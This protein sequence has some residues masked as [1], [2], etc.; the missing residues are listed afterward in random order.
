MM[1]LAV[2]C[3][4]TVAPA[5]PAM[6]ESE[7][8]TLQFSIWSDE[9]NYIRKV[10]DQY[11]AEDRGIQVELQVIPEADYDD[12]LKVMLSGGA[13]VDLVDIRG[14]AQATTYASQGAILDIT[15]YINASSLD[16]SQYG[17]MWETSSYQGDYYTL[18]TRS[19]CWVLYYN[20]DLF[21][22]AGIEYPGQLTWDEYADLAVELQDKLGVYGGYWVPWIFQFASIQSGKYVDDD[23]TSALQ[24][25]LELLNRLYNEDNSHMSYAELTA[26]SAD[27]IAEFENG[28]CAMLPN[29]E[30]CVNMFLEDEASGECDIN[31]QV[32][33]M[34]VPDGV[35]DNTTWG[36]FQ[37]A[38]I[39]STS[40][41]PDEAFDFLSYLCGPEGSEVYSQC[42]M[43]HAYA[44]DNS[45]EAYVETAGRDSVSVFF[46]ANK[47][48]EAPNTTGYDQILTAFNENAQLYLLGEEDIDTC[49]SDFIAQRDSIKEEIGNYGE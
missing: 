29:G 25:S 34:P 39:T 7:D 12:K 23:D 11:N 48:Q 30:W 24:Y 16:V 20:A 13:D 4:S 18:P 41:H 27:Y 2:G 8:V 17:N 1:A 45:R 28:N 36:Q 49:M 6:A 10:V 33:P 44:S 14:V 35:E 22:E 5:V 43:I 32:A 38:A 42:G 9:E 47:I 19:T 31:W 37:F 21:D 3:A 46:D 15:D 40:E 26:T